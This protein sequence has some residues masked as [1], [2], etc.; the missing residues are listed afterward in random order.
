MSENTLTFRYAERKDSPLILRFMRESTPAGDA[1]KFA[2]TVE[3]IEKWVFDEKSA[4]VI[5]ASE[6]GR[7]V[8]YALF[9]YNFSTLSGRAGIYLEDLYISTESRGKRYGK[10]LRKKLAEIA[11]ERGCCKLDWWCL[12]EDDPSKSFFRT[13]GAE[14]V[15]DHRAVFRLEG[16]K[17]DELAE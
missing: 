3:L 9:F 17:L 15:R 7:E 4:E 13:L 5:F 6:D 12:D 11:L 16:E 10:A 1:D 14:F 2:A 8:G